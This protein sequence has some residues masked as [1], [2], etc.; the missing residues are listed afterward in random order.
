MWPAMMAALPYIFDILIQ[1]P[2][3]I[4]LQY[5]QHSYISFQQIYMQL[6]QRKRGTS[7]LCFFVINT[8]TDGRHTFNVIHI[9]CSFLPH[10]IKLA[11]DRQL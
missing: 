11:D 7:P 3:L 6:Q 5:L 1:L 10:T 2:N 9:P 4:V 8:H